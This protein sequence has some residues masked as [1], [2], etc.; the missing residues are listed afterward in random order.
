MRGLYLHIQGCFISSVRKSGR[1]Y[2]SS[3]FQLPTRTKYLIT[4][5][6]KDFKDGFN[7]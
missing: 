1:N 4:L 6:H 7:T 3:V 2:R 5:S